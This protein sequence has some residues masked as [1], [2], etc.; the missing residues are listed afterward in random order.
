MAWARW[1]WPWQDVRWVGVS[2][3][4]E[5]PVRTGCGASVLTR[6][7]VSKG[8]LK[9]WCGDSIFLLRWQ[10]TGYSGHLLKFIGEAAFLAGV[11]DTRP[12]LSWTLECGAGPA[13]VLWGSQT[14]H[15]L[16][17]L[18]TGK[19]DSHAKNHSVFV[20]NGLSSNGDK[21]NGPTLPGPGSFRAAP[22]PAF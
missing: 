13:S 19:L 15:G 14:P 16:W 11:A 22:V 10:N 1:G 5:C 7:E 20:E 17:S 18:L 21:G 6:S 9:R 3:A 2:S 4:W 12:G 8:L